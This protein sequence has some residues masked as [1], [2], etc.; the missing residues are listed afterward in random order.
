MQMRGYKLED[1]NNSI[2]TNNINT[3]SFEGLTVYTANDCY[4]CRTLEAKLNSRNIEYNVVKD[5]MT[6]MRAANEQGLRSVPFWELDGKWYSY[7]DV[8]MFNS[9]IF[10]S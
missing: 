5:D 1:S 6:V 9:T 4:R 7:S 8:D 3:N 10:N 2:N